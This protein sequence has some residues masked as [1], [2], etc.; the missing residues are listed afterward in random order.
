MFRIS[1]PRLSACSSW[2]CAYCSRFGRLKK[3]GTRLL[4]STY[5]PRSLLCPDC[6]DGKVREMIE[7][8]CLGWYLQWG[9]LTPTGGE[10]GDWLAASPLTALYFCSLLANKSENENIFLL[11]SLATMNRIAFPSQFE[12]LHIL[13]GFACIFHRHYSLLIILHVKKKRESLLEVNV[14]VPLPDTHE[15]TY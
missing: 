7:K 11:R 8:F 12:A 4:T 10:E 14:E 15:I 5:R 6:F 13:L 1:P 3:Y 9:P 2:S